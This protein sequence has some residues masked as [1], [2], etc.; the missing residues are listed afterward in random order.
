M[1]KSGQERNVNL[2]RIAMDIMALRNAGTGQ[3]LFGKFLN[4]L[5]CVCMTQ[6]LPDDETSCGSEGNDSQHQENVRE[7]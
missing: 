5:D 7:T 4:L 2:R 1:T 3:K 6:T